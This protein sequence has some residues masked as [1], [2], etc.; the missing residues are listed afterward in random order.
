[1]KSMLH[2]IV[3]ITGHHLVMMILFTQF[4]KFYGYTTHISRIVANPFS[5]NLNN[6]D[7]NHCYCRINYYETQ[8]GKWKTPL[9]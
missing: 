6:L 3:G 2:L 9:L 5:P 4:C 7:Y 8:S 1:M